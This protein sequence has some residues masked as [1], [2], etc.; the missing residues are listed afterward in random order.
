MLAKTGWASNSGATGAQASRLARGVTARRVVTG[1]I[2]FPQQ[3]PSRRLCRFATLQA[4][5]LRSSR[6][7]VARSKLIFHVI[8][9]V[10]SMS[11]D[12]KVIDKLKFVGRTLIDKL[13]FVVPFMQ[14]FTSIPFKTESEHGLT[15]VSGV[16]KFSAAGVVLEFEAKLFGLIGGGIKEVRLPK[17]DILDVR[18]R[19]GVFKRLAKIEVRMKT[20]ARLADL[21]SK[22]GKL[23]LK[24]VRE[25]FER[26]Q[27]AVEQLQKDLASHTETLQPMSRTP[28]GELFVEESEEETQVLNKERN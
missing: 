17:D 24:L 16:A 21:P 22:S 9:L 12:T 18:F 8:S 20:L 26:A 25:D 10:Y 23:T 13:K 1:S 3:L 14:G 5:R 28:V 11:L 6:F 19:K 27:A 7:A 4:G 15:S 2:A